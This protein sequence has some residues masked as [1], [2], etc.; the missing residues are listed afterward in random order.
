MST[1]L[2]QIHIQYDV[3]IKNIIKVFIY[4]HHL[5]DVY[6][7]EELSTQNKFKHFAVDESDFIQI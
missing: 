5:Q 7:L 3:K 2:Y 1:I 4:N 6:I